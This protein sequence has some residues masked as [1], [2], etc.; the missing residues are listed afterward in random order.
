VVRLQREITG[1]REEGERTAA[2]LAAERNRCAAAEAE[3]SAVAASAAAEQGRCADLETELATANEVRAPCTHT[4]RHCEGFPCSD[5]QATLHPPHDSAYPQVA[6]TLFRFGVGLAEPWRAAQALQVL[7]QQLR[8]PPIILPHQLPRPAPPMVHCR[9]TAC[10]TSVPPLCSL[11][12]GLALNDA[13]LGMIR[14]HV[15]LVSRVRS[16]LYWRHND[17]LHVVLCRRSSRTMGRR[18]CRRMMRAHRSC[19]RMMRARRQHPRTRAG[20]SRRPAPSI[21]LG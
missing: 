11:A 17:P 6:V 5:F 19:R 14:H 1:L 21:S 20:T 13:G 7:A 18:R 16:A 15:K 10:C 2:R 8:R 9:A 4:F 3:R 12:A